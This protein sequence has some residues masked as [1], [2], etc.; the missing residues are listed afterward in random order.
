MIVRRIAQT[1]DAAGIILAVDGQPDGTVARKRF[2]RGN[3]LF[4]QDPALG[5]PGF[6][7]FRPVVVANGAMRRLS[8]AEI[9]KNPQY[10][11][12]SLDQSQLGVED[13]YDRMD[14]VM[15]PSPLDPTRAMKEAITSLEEQAKVRVTSVENGRNFQNS[16]RGDATM[17]DGPAIF[18]TSGAWEDFSTPSRDLP[19]SPW[20]SCAH[21]TIFAAAGSPLDA[22]SAAASFA[23]PWR[24]NS[25]AC[26][27]ATSSGGSGAAFSAG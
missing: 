1:D 23:L 13:F 14:D 21:S 7:R 25:M 12:F 6:K 11:D 27:S 16:K 18:E 17:P 5:G 15:S 24:T 9:V 2:W 10:A 4:A 26:L 19:L 3:F 20:R 8:N 22:A